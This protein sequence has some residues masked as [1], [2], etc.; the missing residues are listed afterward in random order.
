MSV[1]FKGAEATLEGKGVNVGDIAPKVELVAKDLSTFSVGDASNKFQI[2]IAVPSLDTGVCASEARKFN[3]K[4]ASKDNVEAVVIS[5]D[6]PFAMGRFCS[7]EGIENLKVGSDFRGAK[8]A[9]EY[10]I[11]L[12]NT[13]LQGLCAR[14]IFVINP[15]GK[16]SYKQI[17]AEITSEPDYQA[18]LDALN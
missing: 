8:F 16:I 11:L 3:E 15:Q 6:L 9:K 5:M 17:V 18:V 7:T 10:G 2:L 12:A 14:A 13:P 1:T 4:I